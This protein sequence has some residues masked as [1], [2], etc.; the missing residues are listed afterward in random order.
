[1]MHS[2]QHY[3]RL[4]F[5]RCIAY[6]CGVPLEAEL[7]AVSFQ[8]FACFHDRGISGLLCRRMPTNVRFLSS[9][10]SANCT[11]VKKLSAVTLQPLYCKGE[12]SSCT[13]LLSKF[14]FASSTSCLPV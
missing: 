13:M 3:N 2:T 6:H 8:T 12:H 9:S 11:L 5:L 10:D 14:L 4:S 7:S 1:M